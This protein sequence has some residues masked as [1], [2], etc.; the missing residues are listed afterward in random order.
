MKKC[1]YK[2]VN[3]RYLIKFY[4]E[5]RMLF[6]PPRGANGRIRKGLDPPTDPLY[7]CSSWEKPKLSPKCIS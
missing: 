5:I 4:F 6:L 3:V 1:N 2:K 7:K